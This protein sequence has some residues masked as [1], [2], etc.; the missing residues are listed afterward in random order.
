MVKHLK[1]FWLVI[2]R[3]VLVCTILLLVLGFWLH[4]GERSLSF[5]KPWIV[6]AINNP[7]APY[8]VDIGEVTVDWRNAAE[9]GK[10]RVRSVNF[11][12]RDGVVFARLPEI[13]ATIDPIGFL[14]TR[15]LLHKVTLREPHLFVTRNA[16]KMVELGMEGADSR[17]A[18]TELMNFFGSDT[19]SIGFS[20]PSLPFHDFIIDNAT[21]TF[22]DANSDTK[23]ISTPFDFRLSRH[24]RSYDAVMSMPFTVDAVPV[25]ISAGLR[26]VPKAPE[27]VLVLQLTQIPSRLLCLFDTCP[28]KVAAEGAVDGTIAAAITDDLAIH[29]FRA[30]LSTPKAL[31]KAPEWFAEPLK[32]GHTSVMVEGDWAK[33]EVNLRNTSL[34]LEDTSITATAQLKKREDGWYV[35]A[36]AET[37]RLD[38]DKI[39][40]YWPLFMAPDSRTWVT[41]KLKSGYAAKGTL[42]LNLTP[43]DMA[44]EYLPEKTVEALVDAREITFE[45]LPNFP[46]VERMNGIAHF[47][48]TTVKVEGSSGSSM[49]GTRINRAVLWCPELNS[50][51]NP[52]EATLSL[53]APASDAVALLALKHFPFDD[54]FGLDAA[55]IKGNVDADLKLKFNAFS[56]N[57]NSDPNEIHLE[58]VDYDIATKFHD[59][60]Q[61]KVYGSYD[62]RQLNGSLTANNAGLNLDTAVALGTSGLHAVT[63]N[64]PSGKPLSVSIKGHE[65]ADGKTPSSRNDFSLTYTSG[66]IPRINLSGKRL[67]ASASYGEGGSDLLA[68]FP[69]MALEIDLGELLLAKTAPLTE[70]KGSL[71]CSAARCESADFS[72]K[73]GKGTLKGGITEVGGKRQF[74]MTSHDAGSMLTAFDITDRMTGGS[75]E[76]RGFYDDTLTPPKLNSRLIISDFTLKN[77]EILGRILSIASLTG[78]ANALTGSGISFDKLSANVAAQ[79][80]RITVDKGMANGTA[81]GLTLA[82]TVDTSNTKLNLKGVIVPAYALNS[83]VGKIP[84][85]GLLAGGEG[86]GLIGFNFSVTGTYDKPDVGV[87]PLS[88]LTPGFL[89]GIFSVFDDEEDTSKKS[90]EPKK[91][92]GKVVPPTRVQKR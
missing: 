51:H 26:A 44:A 31:L 14:P 35:T 17:L 40:K 55:S 79:G 63:L 68:N 32:M 77:S 86:E 3:T 49:A 61:K 81:I 36:T 21:L 84:V 18:F 62:V 48:A 33:G 7:T 71:H 56:G 64:Q 45:Y 43:A 82:G 15:H 4:G 59:V 73:T 57:K 42:K 67:D 66:E 89:R 80:G 78:V 41:S 83:I 54:K 74:L 53:S 34:Q 28:K 24:H 37:T 8:V 65:S 12:K 87:N 69:A 60:S 47:T 30:N 58:A 52:M 6:K 91:K 38:V 20:P 27:H 72:A 22:T 29:N 1:H 23:I 50:D 88:G 16:E 10:L 76:M 85:I 19:P 90:T 25:K 92:S 11:T 70:V 9:L 46:L 2:K 13:Y 39:Y 5:A 75:F